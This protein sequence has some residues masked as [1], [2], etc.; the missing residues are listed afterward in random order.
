[1]KI[2][3]PNLLELSKNQVPFKSPG[4]AW[5]S[6]AAMV[7]ILATWVERAVALSLLVL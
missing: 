2:F 1:M 3:L 7:A 5:A 4:H 6:K